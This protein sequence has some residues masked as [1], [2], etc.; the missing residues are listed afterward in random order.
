MKTMT[1]HELNVAINKHRAFLAGDADGEKADF[2]YCDLSH[3]EIT[4]INLVDVNF[5]GA[6]AAGTTFDNCNLSGANFRACSLL[7]AA[8]IQCTLV[9]AIFYQADLSSACFDYSDLEGVWFSGADCYNAGF[10]YAKN[11]DLIH[12][13]EYTEYMFL[14]CPSEGSFIGWKKARCIVDGFR[15]QCIIKLEI[16][17]DALRSSATTR[18]CRCSKAKVLDIVTMGENPVHV[19]SA[20]SHWDM[21]FRYLVGET[22]EPNSF[23]SN[24]WK[25]CAPGIH[26]YLTKE[27]ALHHTF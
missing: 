14:R 22:V 21:T 1:Q 26:F 19:D 16:P 15:R 20:F 5:A 6:K 8:F 9:G 7:N 3:L 4:G 13:D 17:A 12:I 11:M 24:R 18:K 2:C 25:E 27:E 10:G 23:D